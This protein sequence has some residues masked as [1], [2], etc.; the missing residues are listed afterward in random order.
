MS[1]KSEAFI[2]TLKPMLW[3]LTAGVLIY[4]VFAYIPIVVIVS[5]MAV[6]VL[7]IVTRSLF[8]MNLDAVRTE[9]KIKEQ[10]PT[11]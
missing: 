4:C 10:H 1:D 5:L 3:G 11:V 6:G 2:R 9:R 8:E 7:A